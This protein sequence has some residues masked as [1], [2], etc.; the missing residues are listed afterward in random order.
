MPKTVMIVEDF[1]DVRSMMAILVRWSGYRVVEAIDGFE[2][3]EKSV[4]FRPDLILMDLALPLMDGVSAAKIIRNLEGF[5]KT[6]IVAVTAYGNTYFDKAVEAGF[7]D[8]II[9]PLHFENLEPLLNHY[10]A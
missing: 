3:V 9:K 2:A 8:V 7:D 5:E 4:E 1:I 6:S 10:L